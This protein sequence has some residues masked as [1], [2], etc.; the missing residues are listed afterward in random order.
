[1]FAEHAH[2]ARITIDRVEVAADGAAAIDY[3]QVARSAGREGS[4]QIEC[5]IVPNRYRTAIDHELVA[6]AYGH[7]LKRRGGAVA[8]RQ[9]AVDCHAPR[10]GAWRQC[11][12]S[13]NGEI[14]RTSTRLTSIH[15]CATH[16][17]P[18]SCTQ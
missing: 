11:A 16:L 7:E 17:P 6:L 4:G 9:I 10:R 14:D 18:P 12:A 1:M 13:P 15:Y 2:D 5:R 3:D 8:D